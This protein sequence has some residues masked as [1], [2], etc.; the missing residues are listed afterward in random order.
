MA[1]SSQNSRR[2]EI[3]G[4]GDVLVKTGRN[5]D[6][7]SSSG[8][9]TFGNLYNTALPSGGASLDVLVGMNKN[10]PSYAEFISKYQDKPIYS[11]KINDAKNVIAEFMRQ[12]SGNPSLSVADAFAAFKSLKGDQTLPV[13][14]KLN[15]L[16]TQVF[17]N[18]LK[19][20]GSASAADKKLGNEGG[21]AAIDTLFPGQQWK[22]DLRLFFSR[23]HTISG[24]DINLFVPGGKVDAGLA[25]APSGA[26]SKTAEQLGIVAQTQGQINAFVKDDF[27]V[28]TSR[29]FTLSGGDV[30]IWS[31]E[32]DI[33]AGK[34][35]KTAL[36]VT[37]IQPFFDKD[38]VLQTPPPKIT[39]GSG[40]RTATVGES[41]G[42]VNSPRR[43]RV[44]TDTTQL[45][46][47]DVFL[48]APKGVV[49]AG[50]AGIAGN[51]VTI[52]AVAVLGANNIQVGGISTGVPQPPPS[53]AAGLTGTSNLSAGV[54]QMAET[55]VAA[56]NS[57]ESQ[58]RDAV[59]GLVSVD[60]LGFGE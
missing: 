6:F 10:I 41:S 57:K 21:F 22:G 42:E 54:T 3:A 53:A 29:V 11:E 38:G 55:S 32:G 15:A 47:G 1:D 49:N 8:L 45:E 58:L 60:I 43:R 31:S 35:A 9:T 26:G 17:F 28:N 16:L 24:G 44:V 23:L 40:I 50:E 56:N 46:A 51:N 25:V 2:I 19:I 13:Q 33:D 36:S 34:G 27:N 12:R 20:A 18:E 30:L 39:N 4:P 37:P 14:A 52:S 48:F 59:L 7:G 5:L